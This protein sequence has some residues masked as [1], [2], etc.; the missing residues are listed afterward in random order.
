MHPSPQDRASSD[1][2]RTPE[3]FLEEVA[4]LI[5]TDGEERAGRSWREGPHPGRRAGRRRGAFAKSSAD[6]I[7]GAERAR[8][9]GGEAPNQARRVLGASLTRGE[10]CSPLHLERSLRAAPVGGRWKLGG[11]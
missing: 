9:G 5:L 4:E 2:L 7:P 11:E 10:G 6:G 1:T 3:G 8:P